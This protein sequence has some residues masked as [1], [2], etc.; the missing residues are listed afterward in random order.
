MKN[1][2]AFKRRV[3]AKYEK[4][5]SSPSFCGNEWLYEI[6]R[7]KKDKDWLK[8]AMWLKGRKP[9]LYTMADVLGL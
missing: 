3:I 2:D 8:A 1:E 5:A 7:K 4:A 6:V 9:G